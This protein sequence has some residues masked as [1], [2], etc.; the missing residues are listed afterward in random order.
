ML[1]VKK[2]WTMQELHRYVFKMIRHIL[3]EWVDWSDPKTTRAPKKEGTVD[4][5][6]RLIEFPYRK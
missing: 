1:W 2:S 6:E 5:R 3:S 4:L